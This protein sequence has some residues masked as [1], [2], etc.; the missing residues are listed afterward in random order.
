MDY[1]NG[2]NALM[3]QPWVFLV[4]LT[5][6]IQSQNLVLQVLRAKNR[7]IMHQLLLFKVSL[8][9]TT[10]ARKKKQILKGCSKMNGLPNFFGL[11]MWWILQGIH[12]ALQGLFLG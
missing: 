8:L 4:L 3:H 6:L 5:P 10:K 1:T 11:N 7:P 9:E 2:L 12:G